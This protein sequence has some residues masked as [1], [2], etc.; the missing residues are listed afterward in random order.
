MKDEF[1]KSLQPHER[2]EGKNEIWLK[3]TGIT[4]NVEDIIGTEKNSSSPGQIHI[5]PPSELF[6]QAEHGVSTNV[7]YYGPDSRIDCIGPELIKGIRGV[8]WER[9]RAISEVCSIQL[10]F[11]DGQSCSR[12]FISPVVRYRLNR[13]HGDDGLIFELLS[14]EKG[15]MVRAEELARKRDEAAWLR[16]I[17]QSL[18][19]NVV[20]THRS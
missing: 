17:R 18:A 12:T 4:L 10:R 19:A 9:K 3:N 16:R 7:T 13:V 5:A 6:E 15:E 8:T 20:P 14:E 1:F 11:R 2:L